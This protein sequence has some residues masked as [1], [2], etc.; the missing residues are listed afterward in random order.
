MAQDRLKKMNNLLNKGWALESLDDLEWMI[1]EITGLRKALRDEKENTLD[2]IKHLRNHPDSSFVTVKECNDLK[3]WEE[4]L[5]KELK[6]S[7][8]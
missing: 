2:V 5:S 7:K 1:D 4:S 8:V 6:K 3:D